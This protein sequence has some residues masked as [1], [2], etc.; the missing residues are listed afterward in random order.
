MPLPRNQSLHSG[1]VPSKA[2]HHY[3]WEINSEKKMTKCDLW[4]LNLKKLKGACN[5]TP[6]F[7]QLLRISRGQEAFVQPDL[8]FYENMGCFPSD[9]FSTLLQDEVL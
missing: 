9:E 6:L 7:W 3:T 1:N 4:K 2:L 8:G 5:Q